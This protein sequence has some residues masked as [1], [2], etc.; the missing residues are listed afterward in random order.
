VGFRREIDYRAGLPALEKRLELARISDIAADEGEALVATQFAKIQRIARVSQLVVHHD[1]PI[2]LRERVAR[3]IRSDKT[4]A[5]GDYD[6]PHHD[7]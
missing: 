7:F 1:A 5:T 3:E 2:G 6:R 4:G